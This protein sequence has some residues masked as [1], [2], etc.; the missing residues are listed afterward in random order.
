MSMQ[1]YCLCSTYGV[2]II[3]LWLSLSVTF[4][5]CKMLNHSKRYNFGRFD[6]NYSG[7]LAP[8][9]R[10]K[11]AS[12]K[13]ATSMRNDVGDF[14]TNNRW[15]TKVCSKEFIFR[16]DYFDPNTFICCCFLRSFLGFFE[17]LYYLSQNER[18]ESQSVSICKLLTCQNVIFKEKFETK[19]RFSCVKLTIYH[20]IRHFFTKSSNIWAFFY[21]FWHFWP[22]K[23][24]I[25]NWIIDRK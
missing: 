17:W 10:E 15:F 6:T 13:S 2:Y 25:R 9:R 4:F 1:S 22:H 8:L 7:Y 24:W 12:W 21:T 11:N 3:K 16:F 23:H 20:F 5:T 19:A 14:L 18:N